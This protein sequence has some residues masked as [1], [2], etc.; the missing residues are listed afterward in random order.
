[1]KYNSSVFLL[2]LTN[3]I[4]ILSYPVIF[5]RGAL[6][7]KLYLGSLYLYITT[8]L[9]IVATIFYS[10]MSDDTFINIMMNRD[11][12][13]AIL[14]QSLRFIVIIII[15]K[16]G[17]FTKDIDNKSLYTRSIILFS[18]HIILY[19]TV[20]Y[21]I[22]YSI[23]AIEGLSIITLFLFLIQVISMYGMDILSKHMRNKRIIVEELNYKKYE[24][25]IINMHKEMSAWRHDL[26][27]HINVV[28][29]LLELDEKNKAIEYIRDI[30]KRTSKFESCIY[31]NNIVIDSLLSNKINIAKE[32]NI[33]VNFK[34]KM[35][36]VIKIPN[37]D[38]CTIIGNLMDNSIESCEKFKGNKF[39]D[40]IIISEGS[41]L[42]L[43]VKNSCDGKL[44]K[45]RGKFK[46]TKQEDGHG[47]GLIQID[48]IVKKF[49]GYIN[50]SYDDNVFS[51][52]IKIE[53]K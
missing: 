10:I 24:D 30:E 35:N 13:L 15:S 27:N 25:Y 51:T 49:N 33:S 6:S 2:T 28:L 43:R 4:M 40:L 45:I 53:Y 39:I 14:N 31:T 46:T 9:T 37:L 12:N 34:I 1:M 18:E 52:Y 38:I 22:A 19:T 8:L 21:T 29:G 23:D 3:N 50:R 48:N 44:I 16:Y 11:Y 42:I 41:K 26:R 32:M 5:R 20:R 36:T 7:E 47:F 17:K